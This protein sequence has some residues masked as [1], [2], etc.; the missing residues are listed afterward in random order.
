MRLRAAVRGRDIAD[1]LLADPRVIR[2]EVL[3][4]SD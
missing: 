2:F 4:D 1:R 3:P